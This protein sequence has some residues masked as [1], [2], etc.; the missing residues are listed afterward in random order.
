[1]IDPAEV[2]ARLS[3]DAKT[4][5]L[6]W[7]ARPPSMFKTARDCKAWNTLYAG[8][9]ALTAKHG[10]GYLH[11]SLC[12]VPVL[13]HRVAWVVAHGEWPDKIDHINGVRSDNRLRN[14]RSVTGKENSKN[15]RRHSRNK[16]GITGVFLRADGRWMANIAVDCRTVYLG[17]Y[18]TIEEAAA[19][20]QAA[21]RVLGFHKNHG[22]TVHDGDQG[23]A[24][25]NNPRA[26]VA[27]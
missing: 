6:T 12:G 18:L 13:A 2:T 26:E 9:P 24:G 17:L 25:A 21:Q 27:A 22:S 5:V 7:L 20:R 11:G 3:Y 10:A 23:G 19:A 16:S 4:G 15:C 8:K 14:L 1:M